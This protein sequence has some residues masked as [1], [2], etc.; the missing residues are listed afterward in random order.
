MRT[1]FIF[2]SIPKWHWGSARKQSG[3]DQRQAVRCDA[4]RQ[5]MEGVYWRLIVPS[6][7]RTLY[8]KRRLLKVWSCESKETAQTVCAGTASTFKLWTAKDGLLE[9]NSCRLMRSLHI[10]PIHKAEAKAKHPQQQD[11]S[12]GPD[13]QQ[14]ATLTSGTHPIQM[15]MVASGLQL[16]STEPSVKTPAHKIARGVRFS[17]RTATTC[18]K[19]WMM[20]NRWL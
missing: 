11:P 5:E 12:C 16:C 6:S 7:A 1:T 2:L 14:T 13:T 18:S 8:D 15:Q 9:I 20:K 19:F 4:D 17:C 10:C 3:R